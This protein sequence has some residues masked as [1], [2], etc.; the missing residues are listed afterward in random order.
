MPNELIFTKSQE[1]STGSTLGTVSVRRYRQI[2]V[3]AMCS[4][5]SPSSAVVQLSFNQGI[6]GIP[7]FLDS[8]LLAPGDSVQQL[9]EVP[10]VILDVVANSEAGSDG[11]TTTA[12]VWIWGYRVLGE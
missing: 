8:Y 3:L 9:Y 4:P 11:G 1:V 10:G 12:E 5:L 7:G 2:R 6:G